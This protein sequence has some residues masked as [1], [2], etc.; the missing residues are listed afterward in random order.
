[1][2]IGKYELSFG[3]VKP[4]PE[5][6][7]GSGKVDQFASTQSKS[8]S[9]YKDANGDRSV[10]YQDLEDLYKRTV[11]H[12]V[13]DKLSA[14]ATRLTYTVKFTDIN[15]NPHEKA[16]QICAPIG[17]I[18]TRDVIK[19]TFRDFLLYGDAFIYINIEGKELKSA[20]NINPKYIYPKTDSNN[21]FIGWTYSGNTNG[22]EIDL[23]FDEVIHI[24][25][26]PVTGSIFGVSIFEPILRV[27]TLLLNSQQNTA[28]ILDKFAVPMLLWK[29]D[30]GRPGHPVKSD[31]IRTLLANIQKMRVGNDFGADSSVS[32]DPIGL[33]K[34][35]TV[36]L[37]A[38]LDDLEK[39]LFATVGVPA[40]ILGYSAD[41]LS[42]IVRQLQVYY[43]NVSD[44]QETL[45]AALVEKLYRPYLI[46]NGIDDCFNIQF[47]WQ[48]PLLE[49]ESRIAT[50]ALPAYEAGLIDDEEARNAL[51]FKGKK[52]T[53]PNDV[54][55]DVN[56][57]EAGVQPSNVKNKKEMK[58]I[59]K[60]IKDMQ[61]NYQGSAENI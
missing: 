17:N 57:D 40:Q 53:Q 34:N 14:D 38:T 49:F 44:L 9:T 11:M 46:R 29:V 22:K 27:L 21:K 59:I 8:F 43:E 58:D 18:I 50:W 30:S 19:T 41:N 54:P 13:I 6:D 5:E 47:S 55:A 35:T 1:M 51:G 16:K 33:G 26:N 37:E 24:A 3:K 42:A 32:A 25:N 4:E 60:L 48:K 39:T 52:P 23:S 45:E 12:R 7:I 61:K 10:D 2:R 36:D 20:F 15:D 28:V 31:K 56:V